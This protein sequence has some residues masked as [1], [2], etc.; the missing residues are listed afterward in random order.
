MLQDKTIIVTGATSGI[1]YAAAR[2]FA[3]S[4]ANVVAAGRRADVLEVLVNDINQQG[5]KAISVPGDIQSEAYS[6]TVVDQAVKKFGA[7]HG[8]FNNAGI[9][10]YAVIEE[11]T[12]D[13]WNNMLATNLTGAFLCARSQAPVISEHGGAILFTSSFVGHTVGMP[14]MGAYAAA[15]AGLNG[16]MQVIAAEY[17]R[18]G[19]RINTLISGGVD[20]PM[21]QAATADPTAKR[22]VENLHALGRISGPEEIATVARFL[23]SDQASFITGAAISADGGLS[24]WRSPPAEKEMA[25]A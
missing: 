14:G 20:T 18:R 4:G 16:L 11:L 7:L 2:L 5:G 25:S 24:M 8:A 6:K 3:K 12:L 17:A 1:G 10:E 22:H 15:K 13:A 9:L 23:L 19:V 21:G